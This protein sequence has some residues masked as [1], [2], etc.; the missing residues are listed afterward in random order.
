MNCDAC[1]H[2]S[3]FEAAF[4]RQRR[5]LGRSVRQL[6]ASC[7][8]RRNNKRNFRFL[9]GIIAGGLAGVILTRVSP[10]S[11]L[12]EILVSLFLLQL[13]L[14]CSIIPHEFGHA[15]AARLMGWRAYQ[16]VIG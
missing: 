1:N 13:F 7:W 5:S 2:E 10:G 12:G 11:L 9:I 14:I 6:C 4:I 15:I 3:D 16:M 8:V